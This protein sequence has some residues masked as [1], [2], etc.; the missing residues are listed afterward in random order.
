MKDNIN[1]S[2]N[3]HLP[4]ASHAE[5]RFTLRGRVQ[6]RPAGNNFVTVDNHILLLLLFFVAVAVLFCCSPFFA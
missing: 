3:K 4:M 6:K 1:I 2:S 5:E